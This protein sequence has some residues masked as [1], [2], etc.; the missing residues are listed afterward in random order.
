MERPFSC[1]DLPVYSLGAAITVLIFASTEPLSQ[2][3]QL[4]QGVAVEMIPSAPHAAEMRAADEAGAVVVALTAE[5]RVFLGITPTEPTSLSSLSSNRVFVKADRRVPL[6]T[7][8]TVLDALR[9]KSVVL[10]TA[11]PE[12]AAKVRNAPAYGTEITVAR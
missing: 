4:R 12:R 7:M 2:A 8:L 5:G 1:R 6:E 9:G 11:P 10:L 3:P